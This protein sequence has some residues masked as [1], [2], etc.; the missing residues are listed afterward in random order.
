MQKTAYG[1]LYFSALQGR[2]LPAQISKVMRLLP[3]FLITALV[4][5]KAAVSAQSVTLSGKNLPL[6]KVFSVIE[7]QTGYVLFS[8]KELLSGAKPVSLAVT[9]VPLKKVLD[10]VLKDQQLDYVLQGK[11]IILSGK[12]VSAPVSGPSLQIAA[13]VI[14]GRVTDMEGNALPGVSIQVKETQKGIATGSDGSFS[15]AVSE[16]NTLRFSYVGYTS[17]EI[18]VTADMLKEGQPALSVRLSRAATKL[19]EV[20]VTVN[21]G[22]QSI[23]RERMTGAYSSVQTKRLEGKLQPSLLTALEGQAAGVAITKE[24]KVEV[25]GRST[26]LANGDPLVVIDGYPAPGGLE[27]VNIDNVETITVLKDA[28]AASIYGARSSNGVIVITTKTPKRG[29]L[30]VGYKGSTGVTLRPQLSY[31]NKTNAADYV[32]A[33][34]D[35]YNSDAANVGWDYESFTTY[36]RV[37]QL[38]VMKD[39]GLLSED[40]VNAELN[41]LKKNNAQ[42]Q[43]ER[44]LFRPASTQQHNISIA[45]SSDKFSTNAAVRYIANQGNMKGNSNDRLILDLKNDWKPVNRVTIKMFSNINFNNSKVPLDAN[46]MLDFTNLRIMKPYYNIVDPSGNP[47]A[48]PAVRPDLIDRYASY[49]GLK[50]MEYNPLYDLG[51]STTR[52]QGFLARL[53]GSVAVDIVDGLS[54]EAGGSWTR[55]S[56][57]L[58]SLRGANSLYVR[59]FYNA[60]SSISSPGKHYLPEGAILNETRSQS[61][62]YTLRAQANYGK[63]F[64]R[65]HR[66]SVIAGSEVNKDLVDNNTAPSRM[67]YNDQA[68]TFATFNYLDFNSNAYKSD[69]LFPDGMNVVSNGSYSLRD[70]RF[71]SVYSNG[72]YEYDNRFIL[73]GSARID[74]GNLFGTNPKYRYKPNWSVGGTYKLGQEKLFHIPWIDQLNIRG[75]YGINGNISFTQGPFMLITPASYSAATGGIPYTISSLP[76]NNLRWERTIITNIGTDMRLMNGRLNVTL[77]YYNKESKDLLAPD[78]IDPTYGRFMVTRNAGSA[79]NTG[80]ELSLESDVVKTNKFGWNVFFNGSY[81]KSKVLQF[82]YDY[83]SPNFLTFSFSNTILGSNAGAVLRTGYPLDGVF[84][85]QFAGLDNTGTPQYYSEAGKKIYGN[86]LTVK[87]M[88]YSGTARPKFI[89]SLT[90]TFSYERFDLSFMMIAQIGGVFRRDTYNG[91]NFDHKDVSMRWRKPGDESS[92]IYPKLAAFNTD[93][94]YFPYTEMMIERADFMKLRDLTLSYKLDNKLWGNTGLSGARIYFQGRNLWRLTANKVGIDPEAIEQTVNTPVRRALPMRP[95]F[96]VG[97]SVNL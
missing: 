90:N 78:F 11:T 72:S 3:V 96:Y 61:E 15:V 28:V 21:T 53:G 83:P 19:D 49:G 38:M 88:V 30:Q 97:F 58:R 71:F 68:G 26:F 9:D 85:Y 1:G 41:Q 55:G 54:V 89:L 31:L 29:K 87:D 51:L 47:Q 75:S 44:Y 77:D 8:N 23:S 2:R 32:D 84:S 50:S 64:N 65:V 16:G 12:P 76:D 67:G 22:Y 80:I 17:R 45:A 24:G 94:W 20:S 69:F 25:R 43:L 56:G 59:S 42:D 40:E 62:A 37:T 81:N 33:E 57:L 27:T 60:A 91:D 52:N 36:G 70:N 6:K 35:Y 10:L 74:Q 86:D 48:I 4:S 13:T 82:N 79:R 93:A 73:S 39:Q 46:D 66:I 95:E 92:T 18:T 5:V 7:K 14:T 34:V 63:T